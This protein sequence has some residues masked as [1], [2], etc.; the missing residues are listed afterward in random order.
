MVRPQRCDRV[1]EWICAGLDGEL[2][3][4]ERALVDSHVRGCAECAEF[5]LSTAAF[6]TELRGAALERLPHPIT[7]PARRRIQLPLR[8]V[9]VAAAAAAL[10]VVGIGSISSSL[11]QQN[12][13]QSV[14]VRQPVAVERPSDRDKLRF[15]Q[16]RQHEL[17]VELAYAATRPAG[18]QLTEVS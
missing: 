2:S 10:A 15:R 6:T 8:S 4:F 16:L 3:R 9:Q 7:L 1:R 18:Q 17:Q 14:R 13:A 12:R 11:G 5:G